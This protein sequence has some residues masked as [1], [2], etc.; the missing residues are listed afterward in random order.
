MASTPINREFRNISVSARR[1][2]EAQGASIRPSKD[3]PSITLVDFPQGTT[4]KAVR[5]HGGTTVWQYR[6]PNGT[7][8]SYE[9]GGT[10]AV[11]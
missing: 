3:Y 11:G 1:A 9:S 8:L 4:D 5:I 2:L 7:E 6:L 10:L